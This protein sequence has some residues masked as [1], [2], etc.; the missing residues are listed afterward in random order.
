MSDAAGALKSAITTTLYDNR[1]IVRTPDEWLRSRSPRA[2]VDFRSI[3]MK[4]FDC[5]DWSR[6]G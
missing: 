4:T 1:R 3:L 5:L 2:G 6:R